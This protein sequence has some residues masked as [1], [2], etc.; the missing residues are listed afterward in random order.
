MGVVGVFARTRLLGV[1]LLAL[2]FVAGALSGAAID[3]ALG[4]EEAEAAPARQGRDR[5]R[6]RE[7]SY[8]IDKVDMSADQRSSI[9]SIL[10]RRTDRMRAIWQT[11]EPR[12]E[13]VTDSARVEIMDV[14]TPEQRDRY[15]QL[16]DERR[17]RRRSHDERG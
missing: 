8:V 7:R 14:L 1:G 15:Q 17:E 13:A 2:T 12:M 6:D 9:D 5:D 3:R 10:D 11:V 16:L 4:A